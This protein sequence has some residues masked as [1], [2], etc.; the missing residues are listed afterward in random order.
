MH[1]G[2][3]AGVFGAGFRTSAEYTALANGTASHSTELEDDTFP[4][5]VYSVGIFPGV[6]AL[7]E[8]LHVSEKEV[9]EAFVIAWDIAAKLSL[10]L[11]QMLT[12]HG[13]RPA[14]TT[15][16]VA[17][18]SAKMLKLDVEKTIMAVSVAASH[19]H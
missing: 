5:G 13:M 19:T 11:V 18:S 16:G 7:G 2:S 12:R 3:E 8:K 1:G 9:I 4:E 14:F 15:I 10:P 6:F 17:A